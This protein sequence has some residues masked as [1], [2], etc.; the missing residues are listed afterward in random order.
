MALRDFEPLILA[1]NQLLQAANGDPA[2]AER[3]LED[4]KGEIERAAGKPVPEGVVLSV[5]QGSDQRFYLSVAIDPGF[6]G[7]IDDWVLE[8]VSGGTA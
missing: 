4:A 8:A 2:V 1:A 3:L 6:E 5:R 7:E